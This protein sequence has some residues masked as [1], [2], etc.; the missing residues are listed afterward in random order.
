MKKI[1]LENRLI[2]FIDILGFKDIIGNFD[3]TN[4]TSIIEKI[5]SAFEKS[6]DHIKN[7]IDQKA[8]DIL[9]VDQERINALKKD[10]FFKT[11]SDNI[12]ISVTY[13]NDTFLSRLHLISLFSNAFQYS[14]ISQ[15]VYV[16]GGLSYGS[17][18]FDENIIFSS[19]LVKAYEIENKLAIYPRIVIDKNIITLINGFTKNEI[20]SSG[21][22]EIIYFDWE[23]VA[24]LDPFNV[25]EI[26]AREMQETLNTDDFLNNPEVKKVLAGLPQSIQT[27]AL[28]PYTFFL[29]QYEKIIMDIK[30]K[31]INL[32]YPENIRNKYVWLIEF[33]NWKYSK[34]QT[35]LQFKRFPC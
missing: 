30:S 15:G 22:L 3:K 14:M 11:F 33:Y 5:Q 21:L 26:D 29:N 34:Q 25:F 6:I 16:R 2:C 4:D 18:Y 8:K 27:N 23:N 13:N 17:F 31:S 10:L 7:P 1:V 24:F 32:E 19:G 28:N 20:I 12:I 9:E 35:M